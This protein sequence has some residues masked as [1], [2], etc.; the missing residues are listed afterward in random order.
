MAAAGLSLRS[1]FRDVEGNK[2][3]DLKADIRERSKNKDEPD[4]MEER[5]KS[6]LKRFLQGCWSAFKKLMH[7]L[8][9]VFMHGHKYIA[10][11]VLG[12]PAATYGFYCMDPKI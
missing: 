1:K 8:K 6:P 5:T 7:G 4:S 12:I 11:Y 9:Y 10:P 2:K 3:L